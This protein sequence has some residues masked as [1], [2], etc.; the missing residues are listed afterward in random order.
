MADIKGIILD[1]VQYDLQDTATLAIAS[2]AVNKA[3][4][5]A[6]SI[7]QL[8]T[9]LETVNT[10]ISNL[11]TSVSDVNDTAKNAYEQSQ[12]NKTNI[13]TNASDITTNKNNIAT[14]ATNIATNATNISNLQT[15]VSKKMSKFSDYA[16]SEELSVHRYNISLN[17]LK[18][19]LGMS[20]S[21]TSYSGDAMIQCI[22]SDE[23]GDYKN[24][25]YY[26]VTIQNNAIT[27][28][29]SIEFF[30]VTASVVSNA[31]RFSDGNDEAIRFYI[32]PIAQYTS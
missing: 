26:F 28:K 18:T 27:V 11:Q 16:D 12:T 13:A 5:N 8:Q 25:G 29:D 9:D 6:N 4:T 21:E 14:N 31:L 15:S 2:E 24:Q 20:T 22:T 32:I 19:M 10:N 23:N 30:A 3:D 7:T 1:G 17:K